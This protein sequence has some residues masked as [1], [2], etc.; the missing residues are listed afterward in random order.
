MRNLFKNHNLFSESVDDILNH[1]VVQNFPISDRANLH[2]DF[3]LKNGVYHITETIDLGARDASVKFKEAGLKSF[4]MAKA[5]LE[6]G[7]E[8]RCYAVYSASAA[9]EKD[10][11]EAIEL[12]S[13]G[14]DYSFNLRSQKDMMSYIQRMEEAAGIQ[15]LH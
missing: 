11:S 13:E 1:R 2:A 10:K 7:N 6:L 8:T 4:I 14:S 3:A 9:D 5:K 12:L 15:K